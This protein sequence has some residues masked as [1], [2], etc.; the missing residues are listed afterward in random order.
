MKTLSGLCVA[1][2]FAILSSAGA[3][4]AEHACKRAFDQFC[5][6]K[7]VCGKGACHACLNAHA[8]E[9]GPKCSEVMVKWDEKEEEKLSKEA[10][11]K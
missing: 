10:L 6:G 8:K 5:A 9:L 1:A 2:A 3:A 7:V 11:P 4:R